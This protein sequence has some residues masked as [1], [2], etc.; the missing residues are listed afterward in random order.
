MD[1]YFGNVFGRKVNLA[2]RGGAATAKDAYIPIDLEIEKKVPSGEIRLGTLSGASEGG[3]DVALYACGVW[4]QRSKELHKKLRWDRVMKWTAKLQDAKTSWWKK[5]VLA[6]PTYIAMKTVVSSDILSLFRKHLSWRKAVFAEKIFIT[7]ADWTDFRSAYGSK[8]YA[9][10]IDLLKV[11]KA[12]GKSEI[13]QL[14]K[15][16]HCYYFSDDG[17]YCYDLKYGFRKISNTVIKL[18]LLALATF[19]NPLLEDLKLDVTLLKEVRKQFSA[20]EVPSL[21]IEPFDGGIF[22]NEANIPFLGRADWMQI[23]CQPLPAPEA[24]DS[25]SDVFYW[26]NPAPTAHVFWARIQDLPFFGFTD[27]LMDQMYRGRQ[28]SDIL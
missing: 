9:S 25:V 5:I 4:G 12:K 3:K 28:P 10:F 19:E 2:F 15:V 7:V 13:E 18:H 24:I 23:T 16:A 20:E 6:G 1:R 22:N 26:R 21:R 14:S 17:V 11:I 27:E 8:R